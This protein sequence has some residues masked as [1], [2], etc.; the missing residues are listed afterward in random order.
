[1]SKKLINKEGLYL[2]K[3]SK[4][5]YNYE[6]FNFLYWRN[7]QIIEREEVLT[8]ERFGWVFLAGQL[9]RKFYGHTR[10]KE[11]DMKIR[12]VVSLYLAALAFFVQGVIAQTVATDRL[13]PQE[14]FA[15]C[16]SLCD[17][18]ATVAATVSKSGIR[19]AQAEPDAPIAVLRV[20][21]GQ[22]VGTSA[23]VYMDIISDFPEVWI[24]GRVSYIVD[25]RL[26]PD[27]PF[28]VGKD[29]SLTRYGPGLFPSLAAG[30]VVPIGEVPVGNAGDEAFLQL[31]FYEQGNGRPIRSIS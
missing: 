9:A 4:K 19:A 16:G 31:V 15:R 1:M 14:I 8:S 22:I 2:D 24:A 11:Q 29:L 3:Q 21:G 13:T 5:V 28:Y 7:Y 26:V 30:A 18:A 17:P 12:L 23:K 6:F 20:V 25:G 27:K 10:F